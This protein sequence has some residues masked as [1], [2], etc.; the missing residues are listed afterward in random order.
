M[1]ADERPNEAQAL[2]VVVGRLRRA[3]RRS[4]RADYPWESLP[5]ARVEVMQALAERGATRV[6]ELARAQRLAPNTVS[7][8]V[9]QL[10][11]AGMAVREADPADRRASLIA[12]SAQGGRELQRWGDANQ[13]RIGVALGALPS[14]EQTAIRRAL[15]GLSH[16]VDQ[17]EERDE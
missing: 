5:M 3:L 13:S 9:Q 12:L 15:P 2:T 6:G 1:A 8:L 11:D 7:G 4:I 16:L 10:I 14:A 17:L